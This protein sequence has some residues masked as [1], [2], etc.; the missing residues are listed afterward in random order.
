MLLI[1]LSY[2]VENHYL[3]FSS[4]TLL[5]SVRLL[6]VAHL[7]V[8]L[9][10]FSRGYP[11][12]IGCNKSCDIKSIEKLICIQS[13]HWSMIFIVAI[14]MVKCDDVL[15]YNIYGNNVRMF[16]GL[17]SLCAFC[18]F[19]EISPSPNIYAA[20]SNITIKLKKKKWEPCVSM[21][22]FQN[23]TKVFLI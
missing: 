14:F 9:S 6:S 23:M 15:R 17:N 5:R 4:L 11:V 21:I 20:S 16:I 19:Q 1:L 7:S 22:V 12:L 10:D 18:I 13:F 8:C 2:I 3:S